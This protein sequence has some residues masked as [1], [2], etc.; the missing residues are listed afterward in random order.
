M[1]GRS[2]IPKGVTFLPLIGLKNFGLDFI[3]LQQGYGICTGR[4][5]TQKL[6]IAVRGKFKKSGKFN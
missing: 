3:K 4:L 1:L 6:E 5:S 2:V